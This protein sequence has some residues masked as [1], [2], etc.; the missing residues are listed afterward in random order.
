M[1]EWLD[2]V[3]RESEN[4]GIKIGKA[5]GIAEGI[6]EGKA[7][8]KAEGESMM[9]KLVSFLLNQGRTE[10]LSRAAVD[11]EYRAQLYHEFRIA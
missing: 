9:S 8:G 4:K 2:R 6:A 7:E 3:L 10:D 5:E 11:P 1:S